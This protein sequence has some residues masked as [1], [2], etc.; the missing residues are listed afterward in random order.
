MRKLVLLLLLTFFTTSFTP[1][2]NGEE[3]I[4]ISIG[5]IDTLITEKKQLVWQEKVPTDSIKKINRIAEENEYE[6]IEQALTDMFR[7][8]LTLLYY[9]LLLGVMLCFGYIIYFLVILYRIF[10]H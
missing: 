3:S 6:G 4:R 9:G 10:F 1:K 7:V 8:L 2:V 5:H